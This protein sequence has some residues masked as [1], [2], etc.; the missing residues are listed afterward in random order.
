MLVA[1][2]VVG[3]LEVVVVVLIDVEVVENDVKTDVSVEVVG[4]LVVVICVEVIV[5]ESEVIVLVSVDVVG[6][7]DV[8][9]VVNVEV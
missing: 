3:T 4:M 5:V 8:V 2:D 7:L 9:V 1:V 6:T